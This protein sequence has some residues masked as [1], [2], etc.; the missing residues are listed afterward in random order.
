MASSTRFKLGQGVK[1][2]DGEALDASVVKFALDRLFAA[3]STVPAKSLY[4]D[5]EKVEAVD[6]ATVKVTLKSPNSYLLYNLALCDAGI[7]H[8][9]TAE[10]NANKPVGTGPFSS[11]NARKATRSRW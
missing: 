11:R 5:I 6:P 7:M 2:H 4:T 10:T 9:K 3:N 8:P 1:F